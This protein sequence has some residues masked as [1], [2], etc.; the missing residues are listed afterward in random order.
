M[1]R[2]AC[3]SVK[4]TAHTEGNLQ[5][6]NPS[7]QVPVITFSMAFNLWRPEIR[8]NNIKFSSYLPIIIVSLLKDPTFYCPR[9]NNLCLLDYWLLVC[10]VPWNLMYKYSTG[11][12]G[13]S[14][15]PIFSLEISFLLP[16]HVSSR[17][18]RIVGS[19]PLS[20][21]SHTPRHSNIHTSL[22]SGSLISKSP[23]VLKT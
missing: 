19:S 2:R 5:L 3:L 21:R 17:F 4:W 16:L 7:I 14:V 8:L 22:P 11:I 9:G 10:D 1:C 6:V 23:F 13:N 15:T 18:L 20:P 12:S